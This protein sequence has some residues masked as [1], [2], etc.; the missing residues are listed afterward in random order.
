[1]PSQ[2]INFSTWRYNVDGG[3]WQQGNGHNISVGRTSPG[4]NIGDQLQTYRGYFTVSLADFSSSY[5]LQSASLFFKRA[6]SYGT[7]SWDIGLRSTQPPKNFTEADFTTQVANNRSSTSLS[8]NTISLNA[9]QIAPYIGKTV[10]VCFCG[11]STTSYCYGEID[12]D[13]SGKLP[14]LTVDY[15]Y[16]ISTIAS[17]TN[18]TIGSEQTI[19]INQVESSYTHTLVARC[20]GL[21][22]TIATKSSNLTLTWTPV[23]AQFAQAMPDSMSASCTYTL[24]TY[25]GNTNIGQDSVTVTLS[26]PTADVKPTLSLSVTDAEGYAS[27]FGGKYIVGKSRYT[28]TAN[29]TFYYAT[30]SSINISANGAS[31]TS[32]PATTSVVKS[33]Q[34]SISAKVTDSR[35]QTATATASTTLLAY[36]APSLSVSVGRCDQDGTINSVGAYCRVRSTYSIT[37]LYN[38]NDKSLVIRYRKPGGNWTTVD[39]GI[40]SYADTDVYIFSAD[41][42]STYVVEITLEDYFAPVTISRGLSTADVVFDILNDGNGMGFGMVAQNTGVMDVAWDVAVHNKGVRLYDSLGVLR[43]VLNQNGNFSLRDANGDI[44]VNIRGD[45]SA[46]ANPLPITDG[47]TGQSATA[48]PSVSATA[49]TGS[50]TAVSAKRWGNVISVTITGRNSSAVSAMNYLFR[51]TISGI[52]FP[53][54]TVVGMTFSSGDLTACSINSSGAITSRVLVGSVGANA[55]KTITI[56]YIV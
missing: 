24:T 49:S 52:P 51:G 22:R 9:S 37:P 41:T 2:K 56:V 54:E 44:T 29:A 35:S 33:G 43:A 25:N 31:Y 4:G 3:N 53:S 28:I 34:N 8:E 11:Y 39:R 21:T 48:T 10:Y 45:G 19:T 12:T 42:E 27:H 5:I 17:A 50:I 14:S 20:A 38:L 40:T 47:G 32:S 13:T 16:A 30:Q 1:M 36:T 6:D 15:L 46:S 23:L 26:L 18:G 55:S 7:I